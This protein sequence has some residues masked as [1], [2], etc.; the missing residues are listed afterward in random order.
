MYWS[1]KPWAQSFSPI[2][3]VTRGTWAATGAIVELQH[4]AFEQ[5]EKL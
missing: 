1:T 2:S 5:P 4:E 3:P